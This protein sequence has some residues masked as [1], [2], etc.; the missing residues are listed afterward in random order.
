M[1]LR[2]HATTGGRVHQ[3]LEAAATHSLEANATSGFDAK[4]TWPSVSMMRHG[5]LFCTKT[6]ANTGKYQ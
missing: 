2:S 5:C 4:H 3:R 6:R 1:N